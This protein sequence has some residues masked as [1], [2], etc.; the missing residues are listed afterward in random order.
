MICSV[1]WMRMEEF[2]YGV[3][4][5]LKLGRT[6][7]KTCQPFVEENQ[8]E[9]MLNMMQKRQE[10]QVPGRKEWRIVRRKMRVTGKEFQR[11]KEEFH[12]TSFMAQ[13]WM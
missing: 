7:L 6:L 11:L 1:L 5:G 4:N 9:N 12:D 3:T 2:R 13:R 8:K 10:G